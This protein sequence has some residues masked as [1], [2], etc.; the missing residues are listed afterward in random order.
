MKS[1]FHE[2]ADAELTE[3]VLYYD[4]KVLGLGDRLVAEVRFATRFIRRSHQSSTTA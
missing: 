1:R 2:A 4:R 3:A